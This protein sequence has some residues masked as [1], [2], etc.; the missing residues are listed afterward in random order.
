M[1][2]TVHL[3]KRFTLRHFD[4]RSEEKSYYTSIPMGSGFEMTYTV[5]LNDRSLLRHFD[6]RSLHSVISTNA[7]RRNLITQVSR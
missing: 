3:N 7:V 6:K 2:H 4:E 5:H 1:T